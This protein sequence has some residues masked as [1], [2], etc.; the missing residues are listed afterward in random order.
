MPN[1]LISIVLPINQKAKKI[2]IE[3]C[4]NSLVKQNSKNFE[5]IIVSDHTK[6]SLNFFLEKYSF[7]KIFYSQNNKSQARNLGSQKSQGLYIFHAD[8]D[9]IFEKEVISECLEKIKAGENILVIPERTKV[10]NFWNKCRDLE[11]RI[12]FKDTSI[13]AP[14][15]IKKTIFERLGGFDPELNLLDEWDLYQKIKENNLGYTRINSLVWINDQIKLFDNIK[16]KYQRGRYQKLFKKK[17]PKAEFTHIKI[18]LKSYWRRFFFLL[19]NPLLF[20]GLA[21]LKIIDFISFKLGCLNPIQSF[22]EKK[23]L[24]DQASKTYEQKFFR[25]T[26]GSHYVDTQE[27]KLVLSW[28]NNF[29]TNNKEKISVLDMGCGPGRWSKLIL[30]NF[31]NI[32]ITGLDFSKDMLEK[33]KKNINHSR[34]H[35]QL[36]FSEKTGLENNSFDLILNIRSLKYSDTWPQIIDEAARLLKPGGSFILEVPYKNPLAQILK[37]VSAFKISHHGFLGYFKRINLFSEK[38]IIETLKKRGFNIKRKKNLFKLPATLYAKVNS[39]FIL[40][41][42]KIAEKI[43]SQKLFGRSLF[44]QAKKPNKLSPLKDL[45][46]VIIPSL[47]SEKTI[48]NLLIS[49]K[50]QTYTHFEI[51]VVDNNSKDKTKSIAR[52]YTKKIYNQGPERSGQRNFGARQAKGQWLLFLDSDMQLKKN[53]ILACLKK[54]YNNQNLKAIIIPEISVGQ[55]FWAKSLAL[56]RSCYI[57]DPLIEAARF[58]NKKTFKE[59]GGYD[60]NLIAAEDWDLHQRIKKMAKFDRINEKIIHNEGKIKLINYLRK[61]YYYAQHFPRYQKKHP[62]SALKQMNLVFRPAFFRNRNKLIK[63]PWHTLGFLFLKILLS[64]TGLMAYIRVKFYKQ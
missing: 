31:K 22:S 24:F 48:E 9:M 27:K 10:N 20:N 59:V 53:V 45:V 38:K 36:S 39:S 1:P 56:E 61:K 3:K 12:Y 6:N 40:K 51:I 29:L 50:K 58:I 23:E 2:E 28:L 44:I 57:G 54:V 26:K 14:R 32:Q 64:F 30:E 52:K 60:E 4:L 55:G 15:L 43:F 49:L 18:R 37:I 25:Q 33:A 7:V 11:K 17:H 42:M 35:T 16:R 5:V 19:K 47:N 46:S 8:I 13:E 21:F 63:N 34:F 62:K 41:I